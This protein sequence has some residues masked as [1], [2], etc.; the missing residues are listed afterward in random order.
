MLLSYKAPQKRHLTGPCTSI[1][2][3]PHGM[4]V[5]AR[6]KGHT[7][8]Y[9]HTHAHT[10][11]SKHTHKA[12]GQLS[13]AFGESPLHVAQP[14]HQRRAA[15]IKICV[16]LL[17]HKQ[18]CSCRSRLPTKLPQHA[19]AAYV[20][21]S[22]HFQSITIN[23]GPANTLPLAGWLTDWPAGQHTALLHVAAGACTA[24]A[25]TVYAAGVRP[26]LVLQ[27]AKRHSF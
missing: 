2:T 15:V 20:Q 21:R 26:A 12:I 5:H 6:L 18:T 25:V 24:I 10:Y 27:C 19:D 3:Q 7:R 17:P 4:H 16:Q 11:T 1:Y 8:T 23:S 14:C 9:L 13:T 22:M